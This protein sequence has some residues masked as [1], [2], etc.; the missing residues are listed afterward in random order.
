MRKAS[1]MS[2]N[3]VLRKAEKDLQEAEEKKVL[4][5]ILYDGCDRS[6]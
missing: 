1:V 4:V 6:Y 3:C 2:K 5:A